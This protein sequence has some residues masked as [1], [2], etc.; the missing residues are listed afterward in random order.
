MSMG[1]WC[2]SAHEL[3]MMQDQKLLRL[4]WRSFLGGGSDIVNGSFAHKAGQYCH[5]GS[6]LPRSPV[7]IQDAGPEIGDAPLT[8]I[9]PMGQSACRLPLYIEI[10]PI[11]PL[12]I[13]VTMHP[14]DCRKDQTEIVDT[15]STLTL[16]G[17]PFWLNVI[18]SLL[19]AN[20]PFLGRIVCIEQHRGLSVSEPPL[21]TSSVCRMM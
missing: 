13:D 21:F 10:W 5:Y 12:W 15:P 2:C 18:P 7:V 20:I 19:M 16:E 17:Q 3:S 6:M 14:F 11:T 9:S 1:I 4:R 8:P